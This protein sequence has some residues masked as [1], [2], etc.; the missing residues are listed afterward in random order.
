M[1]YKLESKEDLDSL[2]GVPKLTNRKKL[3]MMNE[4]ERDRDYKKVKY[5]G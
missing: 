4:K 1:E 2:A 3:W 5:L